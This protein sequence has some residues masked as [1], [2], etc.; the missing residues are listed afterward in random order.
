MG[1]SYSARGRCA[2]PSTLALTFLFGWAARPCSGQVAQEVLGPAIDSI[3]IMGLQDIAFDKTYGILVGDQLEGVWCISPDGTIDHL[4]APGQGP[5][6]FTRLNCVAWGRD[7]GI[8]IG[9]RF[10]GRIVRYSNGLVFEDQFA[11]QG[12]SNLVVGPDRHIYASTIVDA[13]G[14]IME[15]DSSGEFLRSL[16]AW[17]PSEDLVGV[18][19]LK[20]A[21]E[22]I[23]CWDDERN[24]LIAGYIQDATF[25]VFSNGQLV[26]T[27]R[28]DD[29]AVAAHDR[30]R[31]Q[32]L[33]KN[34]GQR[35][36]IQV[37]TLTDFFMVDDGE[38]LFALIGG[39]PMVMSL[40]G[41]V[42]QRA[43]RPDPTYQAFFPGPSGTVI[44]QEKETW[45]LRLV[46]LDELLR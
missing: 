15:F 25:Q 31:T 30:V 23:L 19:Q 8:L 37:L 20:S 39:V 4:N 21:S 36:N 12:V 16:T 46:R 26:S 10:N 6:E 24:H 11:L 41:H 9:S 1:D 3:E 44:A 14:P 33:R 35:L 18:P 42:L 43:S 45:K 38:G 29:P 17:R 40:D 5:G 22:A 13:R 7:G 34:P 2:W 28:P 32:A 27:F